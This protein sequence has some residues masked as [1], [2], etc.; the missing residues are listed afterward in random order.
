MILAKYQQDLFNDLQQNSVART[1][2]SIIN[3]V[4]CNFFTGQGKT[5]LI[6]LYAKH[7]EY[8]ETHLN[9]VPIFINFNLLNNDLEKVK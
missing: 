1:K 7:L 6:D 9:E 3:H 2:K 4:D 5:Y 8:K